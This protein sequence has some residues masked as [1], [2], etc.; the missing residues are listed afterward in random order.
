M[1][2]DNDIDGAVFHALDGLVDLFLGT[3]AGQFRNADRP[4][5]K[6]VAEGLGMLLGQQGGRCQ[7]GYLFAAHDGDKS[8]TQGHFGLAETDIAANQPVHRFVGGHVFHDG[9]DGSGL[10]RCFLETK[11]V[12]KGLVIVFRQW[13]RET[14]AHWSGGHTDQAARRR[15]R[16]SVVRLSVW[17]F[18][19]G[20]IQEYGEERHPPMSRHSGK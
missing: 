16:E 12:G 3:E 7:Q 9:S 15:Y 14:L 8:R 4:V 11:T 13:E 5:G 6:P 17:L 10:I 20:P 2:T 1:G 18:P 19:T